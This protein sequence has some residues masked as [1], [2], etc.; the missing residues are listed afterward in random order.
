L[1]LL[2]LNP[3]YHKRSKD[4]K[5]SANKGQITYVKANASTTPRLKG[6]LM[7]SEHLRVP[8]ENGLKRYEYCY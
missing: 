7:W 4:E 6:K 8:L 2:T 3:H 1:S 5:L